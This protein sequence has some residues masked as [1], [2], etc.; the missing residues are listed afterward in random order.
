M[1]LYKNK[2]LLSW[3]LLTFDFKL[4]QLQEESLNQ[5]NSVRLVTK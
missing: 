4:K 3:E 5:G 1:E 2:L